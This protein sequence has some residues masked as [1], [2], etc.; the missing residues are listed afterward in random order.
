M[1]LKRCLAALGYEAT[2]YSILGCA[3]LAAAFLLCYARKRRFGIPGDD[4]VNMTA[5]AILGS[6]AG[7]KLL[8]LAC[9]AP[10]LIQNWDRIV[11]NLKTIEILIGTGFVFYGGLIGCIIAI[12]VYCRT[13]GT[14][15]ED[16]LEM[17]APAIPLFHIFG[18]IGCYTAGCC[19]GIDG[20]PLQLVEA[21]INFVIF[22]VLIMIQNR[23][24]FKGR[25]I[26]CYFIMYPV[27]RFIL[28]FF[29]GDPERGFIGPLSVSQWISLIFLFIGVKNLLPVFHKKHT[30]IF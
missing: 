27:C 7:A 10:D 25:T 11:W 26:Y 24:A 28:E 22:S 19:R 6:L 12:R 23:G 4:V 3:G 30:K 16:S 9:A 15:L 21:A 8:A 18:R 13:Y 20:F 1:D 17:T 29:R 5:Y 14:D 2:W